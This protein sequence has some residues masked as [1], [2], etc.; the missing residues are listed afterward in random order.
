MKHL[1]SKTYFVPALGLAF[2]AF[3]SSTAMAAGTT[4]IALS[5]TA[6]TLET[7]V[8]PVDPAVCPASTGAFAVGVISGNG[9]LTASIGGS[10]NSITIPI[11]LMATDCPTQSYNFSN[12]NLTLTALNGEKLTAIYNGSLYPSAFGANGKPIALSINNGAFTITG[13]TGYFAGVFGSG[14][15]FGTEDITVSPA[16]GTFGGKGTVAFSKGDFVKRYNLD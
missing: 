8:M 16:L 3:C 4:P 5:F 9:T 11:T 15:L 7:L 6:T 10:K 13:G 12:G 14:Q 2:L 1:F